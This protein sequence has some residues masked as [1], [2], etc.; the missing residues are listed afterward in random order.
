MEIIKYIIF[1]IITYF[2]LMQI[3]VYSTYHKYFWKVVPALV[4]YSGI[5]GYLLFYFGFHGGFLWQIFL[6]LF[7]F[8]S[9]ARKQGQQA[10]YMLTDS[11]DLATV[12]VLAKSALNTKK[13]FWLS[14]VTYLIV[15]S[16][17]YIYCINTI[18]IE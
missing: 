18:G 2:L 9:H 5:I 7:F 10:S 3:F 14:V 6:S 16:F 11:N 17:S 4:I 15:F 8:I 13:Y 1:F 12:K